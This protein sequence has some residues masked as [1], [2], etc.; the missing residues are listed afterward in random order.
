M[1]AATS[2]LNSS[3][4]S[5]A[6]FIPIY[7]HKLQFTSCDLSRRLAIAACGLQ[8]ARVTGKHPSKDRHG[9]FLRLSVS[10]A[11]ADQASGAVLAGGLGAEVCSHVAQVATVRKGGPLIFGRVFQTFFTIVRV[12]ETANG[13]PILL[14]ELTG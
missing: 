7:P 14:D 3:A 5:N 4:L 12:V 1:A 11:E 9:A 13:F 6:P 8:A 10:A 2:S